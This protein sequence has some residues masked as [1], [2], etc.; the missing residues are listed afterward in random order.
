MKLLDR[1]RQKIF[2]RNYLGKT[3]IVEDG[4]FTGESV[5]NYSEIK[6]L[7]AYVKTAPGSSTTE[8]FGELPSKTRT[9]YFANG[10]ADMNEYSEVW[11]GVDPQLQNGEPT[12]AHN[13]DVIG[14]AVGLDHTRVSIRRVEKNVG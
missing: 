2:Y 10:A 9:I 13:F 7:F 6:E 14:V 8:P 11:V 3:D 5:K 4:L 1:N 12:I